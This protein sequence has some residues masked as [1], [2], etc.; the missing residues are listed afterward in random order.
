[1]FT[2]RFV[3]HEQSEMCASREVAAYELGWGRDDVGNREYLVG[4]VWSVAPAS[5]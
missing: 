3:A 1:M 2:Q 4:G 5:R